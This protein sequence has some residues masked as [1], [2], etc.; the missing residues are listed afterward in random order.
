MNSKTFDV[1]ICGGGIVGLNIAWALTKQTDFNIAVL[2]KEPESGVHASGRNSG[3]LHSGI[4]YPAETLKS[5]FC[6]EGN[7]R[8]KA[9]CKEKNLPLDETGKVIVAKNQAEVETLYKLLNQATSNGISASLISLQQLQELEPFAKSTEAALHS[10]ETAVV[11][12]KLILKSLIHDLNQTGKATF[13]YN[14]AFKSVASSDEILTTQ[15]VFKFKTFIN[16]AGAYADKL[17]HAFGTSLSYRFI[18]FKGI[19][20]LFKK[21][22]LVRGSIYP[23]PDLR[24]P[25]LGVHFT[26][27]I[28]QSVY[29]GPT[30]IPV[31]GREH[32]HGMKGIT[33]EA[34]SILW[35]EWVLLCKNPKFRNIAFTEPQ[36]YLKHFFYQDAKQLVQ[37]LAP[38]DLEPCLKVGIRPQL[39]N[40]DNHELVMD[41]KVVKH[42]NQVHVLNAIS[43]AF[44]CSI[45]FAEH[46]VQTCVL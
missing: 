30:A 28:D 22:N 14:C 21:P 5:K 46:V 41:F 44:T 19:Y 26:R 11:N 9:Y 36:K 18:P 1:V 24:N 38:E 40:V 3:I 39:V 6:L 13:F 4:Y 2:D 43:P 15:G 12:P 34:F 27:T 35:R 7:R 16:A 42:Q 29:V 25:F 20:Q 23:V 31:F 45:P 33:S 17:A 37:S 32:Y 8:L 10:P